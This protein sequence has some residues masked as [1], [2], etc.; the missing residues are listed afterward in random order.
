M[1]PRRRPR[2]TPPVNAAAGPDVA[3]RPRPGAVLV[4]YAS[5]HGSTAEIAEAIGAALREA[6]LAAE[7]MPAAEARQVGAYDAVVSAA[8]LLR[9]WLR[10]ATASCASIAQRSGAGPS[11]FQQRTLDHS[12]ELVR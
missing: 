11:G 3:E 2:Y 6:G 10:E 4:A 12:A 8:A 5:K 7:V 1:G 9:D